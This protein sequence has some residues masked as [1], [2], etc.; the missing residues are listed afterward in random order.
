MAKKIYYT[1]ENVSGDLIEVVPYVHSGRLA[2]VGVR[3]SPWRYL[4]SAWER[5]Q[6]IWFDSRMRVR[7]QNSSHRL[8]S[9]WLLAK[10]ILDI[11]FYGVLFGLVLQVSQGMQN[12]VAYIVI[13]ILMF[14]YMSG[15]LNSSASVMIQGKPM[16]RA[17]SFPRIALPISMLV[18]QTIQMGIIIAV[19]LA[20]IVALPPHVTPTLSWLMFLPAFALNTLFLL[21]IAL[22]I[23]RYA[24][25]VPDIQQLLSFVTRVL[26]YASG[27][28]FPI[29]RFINH[30]I[31]TQI[32][33]ANPFYI[34]INLYREV[35]MRDSFGQPD[36]WLAAGGWALGAA[37][38]GFF[39]FWRAEEVFGRELR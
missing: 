23:A 35:L 27:V 37:T 3:I 13:G 24:Y 5:R 39:I 22:I 12:Y 16:M 9:L 26:M 10:P 33:E 15:V 14:Q 38:L 34:F 17:F 31:L 6:Y 32:V 29:E 28:I 36:A 18:R 11:A 25:V 1:R 30:P 4:K 7:T 8:G 21:G 20:G 2:P 19:M